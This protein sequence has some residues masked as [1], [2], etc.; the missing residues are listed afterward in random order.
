V[1]PNTT[2]SLLT[3][4]GTLDTSTFGPSGWSGEPTLKPGSGFFI[5]LEAAASITFHGSIPDPILPLPLHGGPTLVSSQKPERA[6]FN[7]IIGLPP[8]EG[9]LVY[10]HRPGAPPLPIES[11]NYITHLFLGGHWKV[12]EPVA[13]LGEAFFVDVF[14]PIQ[15]LSQPVG[16]VATPGST[17]TMAVTASG[18]GPLRYQWKKNGVN[19]PGQTNASLTLANVQA[20]DAGSY[21]VVVANDFDARAS[22]TVFLRLAL[23]LLPMTNNFL[24][25]VILEAPNGQGLSSNVG[26]TSETSEPS[27]AG[28]IGGKSMWIRW[29]TAVPG[30]VTFRT[31]GSS[32]DTLLGAYTGQDVAALTVMASDEDSGGFLTS[33]IRFKASPGELYH[34]AVDGLAGEEGDILLSWEFEATQDTL[35]I[36]LLQPESQVVALGS[37]ISFT[38]AASGA[39]SFQW[40]FQGTPLRDA[41]AT[42]LI[43]SNTTEADLGTYFVRV[44]NGARVVDSQ[45][46][47][48]QFNITG[49]E[50][51]HVFAV[52]KFPDSANGSAPLFLGGGV[53][54]GGGHGGGPAP[55]PGVVRGYTGTQVF[56]T[57]GATTSGGDEPICGVTGGASEW[58]SFVAL[59]NGTLFLNTD[60]S[61]YD[62]V[63][64]VFQ[65]S[66]VNGMLQEVTCDNN[67]GLDGRD[68][69]LS[70][71]V[72]AGV[73]NFIVIDGV[74]SATGTLKLNYSLVTPFRLESLGLTPQMASQLRFT[75]RPGT[76]FSIQRSDDR[77]NWVTL[78]TTNAATGRYDY[79]DLT[80]T[81][82]GFRFYRAIVLP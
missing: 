65:R 82:A 51:Q 55:A 14:A 10:R 41:I 40:F 29:R 23:P 12:V 20:A 72:Q 81:T 64:A 1:P 30:L 39:S 28:K 36:I 34:I 43:I 6:G 38:V 16:Q 73:T 61:S 35:P 79:T 56:N 25:G 67:S 62:T 60:G 49:Q 2:V 59:E 21:T 8:V 53:P 7:N 66:G 52:D 17:V 77:F 45:A 18:T 44:S 47:V 27:H 80:S 19:L 69:S 13:E 78:L 76:K 33:A 63:M 70:L 50:V 4:N 32:F 68:S 71:P 9:T 58:I 3:L 31:T 22:S 15:I 42:T 37:T 11:S 5:F 54:A 48:L 46:A 74:N 26:A 75:G 24:D 57:T